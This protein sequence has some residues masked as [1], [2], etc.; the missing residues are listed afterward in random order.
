MADLDED[1]VLLRRGRFAGGRSG[2]PTE[3]EAE[4][5]SSASERRVFEMP[6]G[7]IAGIVA[8]V[9]HDERAGTLTRGMLLISTRG[10]VDQRVTGR[11]A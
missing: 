4:G 7:A 8:V 11:V 9:A 1:G 5:V 10:Y 6:L 3:G 2:G